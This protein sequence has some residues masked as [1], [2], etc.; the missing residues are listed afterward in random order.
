MR[1]SLMKYT[2]AYNHFNYAH[3]HWQLQLRTI[4]YIQISG[5]AT[6]ISLG[7]ER[8]IGTFLNDDFSIFKTLT[9]NVNFKQVV[10]TYHTN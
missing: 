10:L 8:K 2:F 5:V 9:L 4:T 3:W 1:K 7:C 6:K